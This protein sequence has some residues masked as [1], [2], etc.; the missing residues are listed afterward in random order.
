VI[1]NHRV[2]GEILCVPKEYLLMEITAE[3]YPVYSIGGYRYCAL[4]KSWT[5]RER[6]DKF[7]RSKNFKRKKDNNN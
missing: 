2:H 4:L 7:Y 6:A 1:W 3:L 5:K